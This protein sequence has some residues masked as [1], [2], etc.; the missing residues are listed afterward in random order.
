MLFK[1]FKSYFEAIERIMQPNYI[2]SEM[3]VLRARAKTTGVVETD[4]EVRGKRFR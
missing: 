3:D 4:F 1:S 2:P